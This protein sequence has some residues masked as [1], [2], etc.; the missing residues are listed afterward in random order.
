VCKLDCVHQYTART[1]PFLE[2]GAARVRDALRALTLR[3]MTRT[4]AAHE[5]RAALQR[6]RSQA[7]DIVAQWRDIPVRA[8]VDCVF[9]GR[10]VDRAVRTQAA[11]DFTDDIGNAL[12]RACS[13]LT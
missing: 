13:A 8:R 1:L 3:V 11:E 9:A 7:E 4:L 12:S 6:Q 5:R 2:Q 10:D